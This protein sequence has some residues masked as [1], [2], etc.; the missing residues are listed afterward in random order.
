MK[1]IFSL[2]ALRRMEERF[3]SKSLTIIALDGPDVLEQSTEDKKK[4]LAKKMYFNKQLRKKHLLMV[5]Y[6]QAGKTIKIITIIDTSK[7][8]KYF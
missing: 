1:I 2:H 3:I 8:K 6:R 5:I 4:F 7:V